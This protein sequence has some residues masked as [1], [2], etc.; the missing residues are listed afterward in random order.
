M[1]LDNLPQETMKE[2]LRLLAP[3]A[4]V[5]AQYGWELLDGEGYVLDQVGQRLMHPFFKW[6]PYLA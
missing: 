3:F 6:I 1:K 4:P 5:Y 2:A